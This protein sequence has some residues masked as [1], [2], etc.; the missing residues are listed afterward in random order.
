MQLPSPGAYALDENWD[1]VDAANE[2]IKEQLYA[3]RA[4]CIGFSADNS[5]PGR[6]QRDRLHEPG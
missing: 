2:A 3:G 5:Q 1:A 4:A 6:D